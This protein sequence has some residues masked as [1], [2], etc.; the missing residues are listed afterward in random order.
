LKYL[1]FLRA[2]LLRNKLRFA[3]TVIG[4]SVAA[5]LFCFLE[6]VVQVFN[7]TGDLAGSERLV[8]RN[9]VSLVQPLPIAYREKPARI[10]GVEDVS[11]ASWFGGTWEA[12]RDEYFGQFAV[13]P[14]SYLRVSPKIELPADQ[15]KAF[16]EDRQG[17]ILGSNLAVRLGKK[18][19]DPIVLK[20]TIYPGR[21]EFNVRGI[22]TGKDRSVDV[23][24]MF[25]H[26]DSLD[27]SRP[28]QQQGLVGIY[29]LLLDDPDQAA[30]VSERVDAAFEN[31][32]YETRTETEK[33][34]VLGFV[35]M[36]GNVA[37]LLRSIG[38]AVVFTIFMVVANTMMMSARERTKEV[39]ILKTIGF[40]NR[41][42][43]SLYV[44]EGIVIAVLG[45]V[46]GCLLAGGAAKGMASQ[47]Q[48][49]IPGGMQISL[50]AIGISLGLCLLTGIISGLIPAILAARLSIVNALQRV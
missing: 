45:G 38:G 48:Q 8:V 46:L 20:G 3:L 32:A 22:Y 26:W 13:D 39:G 24:T 31:S 34:F 27:Q 49:F 2:N 21:W 47:S 6:S 5:F 41:T 7:S 23:N 36:W 14:E 9:D 30:V 40:P 28:D 42:V 29:Y 12:D 15:K 4:I 11:W 50:S 37:L 1:S 19:G 10:P 18:V 33:A 17:C 35:S 25:F 43:A 44:V 16:F